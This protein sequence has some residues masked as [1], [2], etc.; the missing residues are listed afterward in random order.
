MGGDSSHTQPMLLELHTRSCS[1]F[2]LKASSFLFIGYAKSWYFSAPWSFS[3]NVLQ[4]RTACTAWIYSLREAVNILSHPPLIWGQLSNRGARLTPW[5]MLQQTLPAQS[6]QLVSGP[7]R[8]CNSKLGFVQSPRAG[9]DKPT[10]AQAERD[11]FM[12]ISLKIAAEWQQLK[13]GFQTSGPCRLPK[14]NT[15]TARNRNKNYFMDLLW[16]QACKNEKWA[17]F[18]NLPHFP[19][20]K[21]LLTSLS[22][23]IFLRY[24]QH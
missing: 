11:G 10:K 22:V 3:I 5:F 6:S 2:Q 24:F 7:G 1:L 18:L 9:T 8:I 13:P 16:P 15:A 21:V 19:G 17:G 23:R 20:S 12:T 4:C 14:A